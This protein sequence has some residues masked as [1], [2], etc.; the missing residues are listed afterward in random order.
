MTASS[1]WEGC[2]QRCE[3]GSMTF[4]QTC[5]LYDNS[6]AQLFPVK[7]RNTALV[8][9]LQ[10]LQKRTFKHESITVK[11]IV[12]R[13][14]I[15]CKSK[16]SY[17]RWLSDCLYRCLSI[18]TE[19]SNMHTYGHDHGLPKVDIFC[20]T[21][22]LSIKPFHSLLFLSFIKDDKLDAGHFFIHLWLI[23]VPRMPVLLTLRALPLHIHCQGCLSDTHNVT[24][25]NLKFEMTI[26][27]MLGL[28]SSTI[29]PQSNIV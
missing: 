9:F 6:E 15:C 27:A 18:I 16:T 1:V 7:P 10:M 8:S 25:E 22:L 17:P 21:C 28:K 23:S 2:I 5:G 19:L 12:I 4:C 24:N 11:L 29:N 20:K 26:L 14:Y 3:R 13:V